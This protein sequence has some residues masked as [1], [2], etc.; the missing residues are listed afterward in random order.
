[1]RRMG[2]IILA[3]AAAPE[4]A[5]LTA[6]DT[7]PLPEPERRLTGEA[8]DVFTI[9]SA[10]G[11][12]W[13]LFSGVVG[14]AFDDASNLYVLDRDGARVVVVDS[15]GRFLRQIGR[16]GGGP[17]ELQFPVGLALTGGRVAVHDMARRSLSVFSLEGEFLHNVR[18]MGGGFSDREIMAAGEDVIVAGSQV[19]PPGPGEELE[20]A[21]E[22]PL[23]RATLERR[24]SLRFLFGVP[25]VKPQVSARSAGGSR[26]AM[27][28]QP[29]P[30]YSARPLW[31][32]LPTGG[33]AAAWSADHRIHIIGSDGRI[34]R[35]L[36]GPLRPRAVSERDRSVARDRLREQLESGAGML[37]VEARNGARSFSAG[38][39]GLPPEEVERRLR[40]LT[41]AGSVPV[42]ARLTA[43]RQG[44][45]WVQ[46]NGRDLARS[47]PLDILTAEGRYVGTLTEGEIPDAFGPDGLAAWIET[48][49]LG[50]ERVIVKRLPAGWRP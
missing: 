22:L 41:F 4:P 16:K 14:V 21:E 20:I 6:Q 30:T 25:A 23:Y 27:T 39:G 12:D 46:R 36:E 31:T 48:D 10:T 33:V 2:L 1:M 44:R 26:T 40:A 49:E 7:I 45:L 9:G 50:V 5:P 34:R 38:G 37:R 13:E 19:T 47:G 8:T 3:L 32:A 15:E 43:D 17:G 24:D 11:E 18:T 42:I 28:I 29:P 35:V